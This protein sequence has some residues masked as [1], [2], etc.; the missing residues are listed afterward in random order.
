MKTDDLIFM[1][2]ND[3]REVKALPSII[4][5][6]SIG[7]GLIM[8]I[9]IIA[10]LVSGS[11][12]GMR[13]DYLS[14]FLSDILVMA[15]Q[16]APLLLL[17]SLLPIVKKMLYPE[18]KANKIQFIAILPFLIL[19]VF[20]FSFSLLN[21]PQQNWG[22]AIQGKSLNFCIIG[23]P[24]L[25]LFVLTMEML[26]LKKG[27]PTNSIQA[28]FYSGLLAGA[29]ACF[30]YAFHCTE[31]NPSFYALWYSVGIFISGG[32]GAITGRLFLKW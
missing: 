19:M 4:R 15:K 26:W 20:L 6:L 31:D 11:S 16:I 3:S 8:S 29:I 13:E 32:I 14:F 17:F 5:P 30:F 9:L 2:S 21:E 1:L 22:M 27:A 23:I 24:F 12:L 7:A 28:G 18:I 10:T 25:S